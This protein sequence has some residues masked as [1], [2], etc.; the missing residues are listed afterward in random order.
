MIKRYLYIAAAVL[1][2]G[3]AAWVVYYFNH[4]RD[5][6]I[7]SPVLAPGIR[8]KII[9]D[10]RHKKLT[11]ITKDRTDVLFLPDRPTSIEIPHT[12]PI[13]ITR[14]TW[15]W[16]LAPFGTV[17]YT[18]ALRAGVGADYFYW[19][20]VDFGTGVATNVTNFF[21]IRFFTHL[22]YN[23]YS[24]TSIGIVFDSKQ[25]VGFDLSFRF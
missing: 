10:P 7:E 3:I 6:A 21:D 22:G 1:T 15:G 9:V 13:R 12:G 16:E 25:Q 14:R 8:E 18:D 5:T 24:N 20:K 11:V 19:R 17:V 4:K 23:V 2:L